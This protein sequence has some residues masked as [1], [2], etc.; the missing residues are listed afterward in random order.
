MAEATKTQQVWVKERIAQRAAMELRDGMVV[1][2]GIGLPTMVPRYLPKGVS[3]IMQS[4]NGIIGMG[5]G[6][7]QS[8]KHVTDASGKWASVAHGGA[9]LDSVTSFGLI[10]G[11]HID[12]TILGALQVDRQGSLANWMIPGKKVPGMG[13]AMDL[14]TGIKNVIVAMEHTV[15]GVPK[16]VRECTLP[17]TAIHCVTKIIT[18]MCV[19]EVSPTG[20]VLTEIH[21][22]YTMDQVKNATEADFTVS[23]YLKPYATSDTL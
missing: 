20:L 1:N 2:L 9:F 5:A 15:N 16:I 3:V 22:D 13:G 19:F 18:E 8:K 12:A 23:A 7:Q 21:P 10:R 17:Y 14:L 6:G 11:G 4:E